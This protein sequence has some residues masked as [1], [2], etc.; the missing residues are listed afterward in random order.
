MSTVDVF[1]RYGAALAGGDMAALS[2]VFAED[3]VWH[4]PG[5]NVLSGSHEGRDAVFALLGRF[6][7]ISG[8]TFSLTVGDVVSAG[9]LVAATTHFTATRPGGAKL[10]QSGVDIFRIIGDQIVEVWLISEDQS[11]ED[12]FWGIAE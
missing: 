5:G 3:I 2:Q 9:E 6:A 10:D 8:E 1:N 11:A 4:Q 12:E 7:E